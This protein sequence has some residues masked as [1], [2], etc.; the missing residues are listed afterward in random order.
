MVTISRKQ[1]GTTLGFLALVLALATTALW[2]RQVDLVAIPENRSLWVAAFLLAVA[3]SVSAFVV[4]TR[5]FGG[6]A[7][8]LAVLPALFMPLTMAI[9]KQEVAENPIQ[10]GDTIPYFAAVTDEG[11]RFTSRDLTGVPVVIKFFRAHW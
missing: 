9:S 2:F 4:G 5:W 10:V 3:M 1:I 11:D 7:A 8:V 6:V